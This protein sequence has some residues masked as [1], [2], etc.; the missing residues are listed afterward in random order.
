MTTKQVADKLVGYCRQGQFEE[1]VKDLYA[2]E[3]VSIEPDGSPVK[4]VIGLEGVIAK[5]QQFND[6]VEEFHSMEVSDPLVADN[7]FSCSMKMDITFKDMPRTTME[8][9]CLYK[10]DNGK[11]IREEF[12]FTPM[13][14]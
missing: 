1:A 11:V 2:N 6:T 9:V 8:E 7:F 10:V 5:G 13:Q 4:E 12:F 14:S 3:I